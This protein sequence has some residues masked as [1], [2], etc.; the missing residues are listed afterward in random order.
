MRKNFKLTL[1][2]AAKEAIWRIICDDEAVEA[3]LLPKPRPPLVIFNRY[4]HIDSELESICEPVIEFDAVLF[5]LPI[6]VSIDFKAH[7]LSL[8]LTES[9]KTYYFVKC[10]IE[11]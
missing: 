3:F 10:V 7:V 6:E 11:F 9:L 2:D 8:E 4:D 5:L 1:D